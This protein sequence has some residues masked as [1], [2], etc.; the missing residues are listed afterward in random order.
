MCT[1]YTFDYCAYLL[2]KYGMIIKIEEN[3]V[4]RYINSDLAVEKKGFFSMND[5][6]A[7]EYFEEEKQNCTICRL[8][9]Y[10]Q[11][12]ADKYEREKG[13]YVTVFFDEV[14]L[15]DEKSFSLLADIVAREI[16]LIFSSVCKNKIESCSVLVVGLGNSALS[17]DAIGPFT[18]EKLTVTRHIQKDFSRGSSVA[19]IIPGVLSKTGIESAEL[20]KAASEN[21]SPDVIIVVDSLLAA[22][23]EN[24]GKTVQITDVGITPGSG[25]GNIRSAI[26]KESLGV[27]VISIGVPSVVSSSTLIIDALEKAGV[28][29]ISDELV[30]VLRDGKS[31]FVTPREC[32]QLV[33]RASSLLAEALNIAFR[34]YS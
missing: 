21:I 10:D 27:P 6:D 20:V 1:K 29:E 15:I 34:T 12:L 22:R 5:A 19:A 24:L 9:I 3:C 2:F 32:D 4:R 18:V 11:N 31:F 33:E 13:R 23:C 17:V 14:A 30:A 16:E 25:V 26:N 8:N 28:K 7:S